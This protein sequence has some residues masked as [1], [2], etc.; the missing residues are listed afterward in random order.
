MDTNAKP[1]ALRRYL[2]RFAYGLGALVLAAALVSL[3]WQVSPRF[4]IAVCEVGLQ[5]GSL[6]WR[7]ASAT[8]L[9]NLIRDFDDR[10]KQHH[11]EGDEAILRRA[12][13]AIAPAQADP[14]IMVRVSYNRAMYG[15]PVTI[16]NGRLV[17]NPDYAG[18]PIRS[19]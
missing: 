18:P 19:R 11:D 15:A 3:T 6:I 10:L 5:R 8:A 12:N 7:R 9:A 4:R 16:I 1:S 2:R 17:E 14:D 13:E